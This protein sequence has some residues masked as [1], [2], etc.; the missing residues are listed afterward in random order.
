MKRTT[1]IAALALA[2][3]LAGAPAG[4]A[5]ASAAAV[6]A[7]PPARA[8]GSDTGASG[9]SQS[10]TVFLPQPAASAAAS[11][12]PAPAPSR[13]RTPPRGESALAVALTAALFAA[14]GLVWLGLR[15]PT[16]PRC[17]QRLVQLEPPASETAGAATGREPWACLGCGVVMR[18]RFARLRRGPLM[19]ADDVC[20]NCGARTKKT[21]L[22]VVERPG[23]LTWGEVRLDDDCLTCAHRGSAL[24]AAPSLEA[25]VNPSGVRAA[26][27]ASSSSSR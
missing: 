24:Y 17:R 3:A 14:I 25:P 18:R 6:P 27:R 22:T 12:A 19:A 21:R 26:R 20:A 10:F 1:A 9:D 4:A 11:G 15:K 8:Q 23:Y 16:C 7:G 13:R 2:A 5:A